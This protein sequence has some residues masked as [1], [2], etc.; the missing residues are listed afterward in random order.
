MLESSCRT[1]DFRLQFYLQFV[2]ALLLLVLFYAGSNYMWGL[3]VFANWWYY[4]N[5][6]EGENSQGWLIFFEQMYHLSWFLFCIMSLVLFLVF[7]I[8]KKVQE[9][10]FFYWHHKLVDLALHLLK[11]IVLLLSIQHGIQGQLDSLYLD[12]SSLR[13][14]INCWSCHRIFVFYLNLWVWWPFVT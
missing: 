8:F 14:H 7:R 9:L 11:Q 13:K 1:V 12:N 10:Q 3:Q 6:W 2:T 4:K 5:S